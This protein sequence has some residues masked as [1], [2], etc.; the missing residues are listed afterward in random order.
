MYKNIE[1]KRE[2]MREWYKRHRE[3][4]LAKR[5]EYY[6]ENKDKCTAY[7]RDWNK[8]NRSK[9]REEWRKKNTEEYRATRRAKY[10]EKHKNDPM[11]EHRKRCI[12]AAKKRME[13]PLYVR[14]INKLNIEAERKAK[15]DILLEYNQKED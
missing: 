12:E 11:T 10:A 15:R 5:A 3:K 8:K 4:V 14:R 13:T 7:K 9:L 1:E 2:Y 6:N